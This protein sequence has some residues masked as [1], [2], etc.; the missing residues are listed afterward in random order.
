MCYTTAPRG[1]L[2]LEALGSGTARVSEAGSTGFLAVWGLCLMS[3]GVRQGVTP[4][5]SAVSVLQGQRK[6]EGA[7]Q[8]TRC[9]VFAQQFSVHARQLHL[10]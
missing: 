2:K 8:D 6:M 9:Q 1:F 10:P 4:N 3:G 7:V 5:S